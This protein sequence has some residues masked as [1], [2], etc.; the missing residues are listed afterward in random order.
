MGMAAVAA[1]ALSLKSS[2]KLIIRIGYLVFVLLALLNVYES[3]SQQG[4]LVFLAGV[5]AVGYLYV[6]GNSNLKKFSFYTSLGAGIW[7]II[8]A[9]IG[10]I[11]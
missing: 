11:V 10:S 8:L 3:K 9:L 5:V 7:V 1:F 2:E 6:R 4:Y